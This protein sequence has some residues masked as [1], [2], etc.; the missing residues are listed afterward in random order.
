MSLLDLLGGLLRKAFANYD[1]ESLIT[2]F[3]IVRQAALEGP[4][5]FPPY[6]EWFKVRATRGFSCKDRGASWG[7]G[8][9]ACRLWRRQAEEG[10][11]RRAKLQPSDPAFFQAFQGLGPGTPGGRWTERPRVTYPA[12]QGCLV[13]GGSQAAALD[14]GG[15]EGEWDAG[16]L[17]SRHCSLLPAHFWEWQQPPWQQQEGAHLL[18]QVPVTAG[19]LRSSPVP[20]GGHCLSSSATGLSRFARAGCLWAYRTV[21]QRAG[22]LGIVGIES[23]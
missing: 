3:L 14:T 16:Q 9:W 5:L 11:P 1:L 6:A 18:L 8:S 12:E 2:T 21:A 17:G 10:C 19:S 22:W 13:H 20:E 15:R 4:A 7:G 23:K